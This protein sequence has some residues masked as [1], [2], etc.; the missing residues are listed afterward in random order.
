MTR[1]QLLIIF[2]LLLLFI[3]D[4]ESGGEQPD[5]AAGSGV[6]SYGEKDVVNQ[7]WKG[8]ENRLKNLKKE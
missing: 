7:I 8:T 2:L 4:D 5:Y 1:I 3:R 6:S